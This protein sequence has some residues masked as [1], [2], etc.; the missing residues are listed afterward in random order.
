MKKLTFGVCLF[1]LCSTVW[2]DTSVFNQDPAPIGAVE[3]VKRASIKRKLSS[4]GN[5]TFFKDFMNIPNGLSVASQLQADVAKGSPTA[6][7]TVTRQATNSTYVDDNGVI[8]LALL[9]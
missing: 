1:F 9:S 6:T 5:L 8:Q 4:F 3:G 7:F 2:A